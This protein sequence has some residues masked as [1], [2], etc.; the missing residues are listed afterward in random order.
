[1]RILIVSD[2]WRPQVNGVV[3]TLE[4]LALDAGKLGHTVEFLTPQDYPTAPLPGYPEIQLALA[5]PQAVADAIEAHNPDAL[6]ISTEGPLG[7]LARHWAIKTGRPFTTCYHTRY[8]QYISARYPIPE[9]LTYGVMRYF[10]NAGVATMVATPSLRAELLDQGFNR[11][12][13]WSRGVDADL[14]NP[15]ARAPMDLP[16]PI[17]LCVARVAVEKNL[18]AFLSLD[19]PGSKLIVGDGPDR[20]MLEA[21]YPDAHF[22]GARFG[23]DLARIYASAD[24]FVFPSKTETFGLVMLEALASGTPV[25][26]FPVEGLIPELAQ[27]GAGIMS[28]DLRAAALKALN[29]PRDISRQFALGYS[30]EN[31]AKQFLSNVSEAFYRPMLRR[32]A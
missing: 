4:R 14:F 26:A 10:H 25:A 2:A 5:T 21:K 31:A 3:R 11:C 22:L 28:H 32:A 1:M 17:F 20:A 30:H 29:I 27:A 9:A 8:P 7:W 18:E 6:H 23:A 19:L 12:L 24:A 13:I 16:G 15:E